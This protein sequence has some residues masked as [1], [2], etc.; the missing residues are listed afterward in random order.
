MQRK[1]RL[2]LSASAIAA[3]KFCPKSFYNKYIL[4]IRPTEITEPRRVGNAWHEAQEI[5][6]AKPGTPCKFCS[7]EKK[8]DPDCYLCAGSG[9]ID[10]KYE[11]L[12]RML[13]VRYAPSISFDAIKGRVE[14]ETVLHSVLAYQCRYEDSDDYEVLLKEQSFS[15]PLVDPRT[16]R[17]VP[18]V[19]I[20]GAL[21]KLVQQKNGGRALV[22]YK[23]TSHDLS[24]D[25]TYWSHLRL[26][27][28]LSLY[29]YAIQRMQ[30][31]GLL[32]PIKLHP[33]DDMICDI[34]FD[35][36]RKPQI[37]PKTLSAADTSTFLAGKK[38]FGCE[39]DIGWDGDLYNVNWN[40]EITIDGE[41]VPFKR[42]K[43]TKKEP[44]GAVVLAETPE[45]F[46]ARVFTTL[47]D[48]YD[49]YFNRRIISRTPEEIMEFEKELFSI[50]TT[51]ENMTDANSWYH[52]EHSCEATFKCD[53]IDSCY[54]RTCLDPKNPPI[55]FECIYDNRRKRS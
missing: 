42:N 37:K 46:G 23:S 16:R 20:N 7:S 12:A 26:D 1:R 5:M 50:Y 27:T 45:M 36:W 41:I 52:N 21:D 11:A 30:A 22:E 32:I 49:R 39:F 35:V 24:S 8:N 4:G 48:D 13:N 55:G 29:V 51:I 38:Y 34:L 3:F 25:S 53:Y 10:D 44:A 31:D 15:I 2:V 18:D 17:A 19:F 47:T 14:R 28:Q 54:T 33:D 43:P 6:A 9:F 40:G